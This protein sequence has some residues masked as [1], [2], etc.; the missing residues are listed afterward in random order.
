MKD[1]MKRRAELADFLKTRRA[2]V[3]PEQFGL[4]TSGRRRTPGLRR[5]EVAQLAE[6]VLVQRR[7]WIFDQLEADGRHAIT[8]DVTPWKDGRIGPCLVSRRDSLRHGAALIKRSLAQICLV[9]KQNMDTIFIRTSRYS[10]ILN[11]K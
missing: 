8:Q 4:L 2:R 3:H 1:D 10:I 7:R 5:D 11:S 6:D 9:T